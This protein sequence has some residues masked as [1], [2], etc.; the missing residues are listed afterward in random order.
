M[1]YQI[2]WEI[3]INYNIHLFY[4]WDIIKNIQEEEDQGKIN[5]LSTKI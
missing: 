5:I 3:N 1:V 2:V 4:K